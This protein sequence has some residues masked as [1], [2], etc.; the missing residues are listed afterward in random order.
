MRRSAVRQ[1]SMRESATRGAC[2]MMR[3]RSACASTAAVKAFLCGRRGRSAQIGTASPSTQAH[4]MPWKS[5]S[6]TVEAR[7]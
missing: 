4:F 3:P 5:S 6:A 1:A 2:F 7:P